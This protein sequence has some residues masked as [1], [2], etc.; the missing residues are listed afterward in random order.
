[1]E[2]KYDVFI[3]YR[4][5]DSEGDVAGRDI[6]RSIHLYLQTKH[7]CSFFDY[8]ECTDGEFE[9]VII[10][11]VRMSHYFF[12]IMTN[13]S[14]DRCVNEGD[15]V[16]REI[17]EAINAKV[18]IIPIRIIDADHP[19]KTL[20]H[21]P[22]LPSPMDYIQKIQWSEISM[23][24]L[25]E[26]SIDFIIENRFESDKEK[27]HPIEQYGQWGYADN[28]GR[29]IIPCTWEYADEFSNGLARVKGFNEKMGFI[30]KKGEEI[31]PCKWKDVGNF[32]EELARVKND[33]GE[34]GF[35]NTSGVVTI[36]CEWKDAGNFSEGLVHVLNDKM[37][38]G[39][40][41]KRGDVVIPCCWKDAWNF[42]GGHA[43]V[44]D[45]DGNSFYIDLFGNLE[46][47]D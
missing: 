14:L 3:S 16:R 4:R 15:W 41:N 22:C 17:T 26:K 13:G 25:F 45:D 5:K 19:Q 28:M 2:K 39:Y 43:R 21:I 42:I 7:I 30:N 31:V 1:M 29:V 27:L 10:P 44:K 32:S 18:K 12:I 8:S 40:I 24:V 34:T 9:E 6:A 23:G 38:Y 35:I 46:K 20:H 37:K 36:P 11:A 33:E 47:I